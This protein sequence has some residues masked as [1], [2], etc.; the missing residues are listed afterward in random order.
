[1][2]GEFREVGF[3]EEANL[4]VQF[5]ETN[6]DRRRHFH[7]N[8]ILVK[9]DKIVRD[10]LI[11][12]L[13]IE[14]IEFPVEGQRRNFVV[15]YLRSGKEYHLNFQEAEKL[16]SQISDGAYYASNLLSKYQEEDT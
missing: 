6:I 3:V 1:M 8:L 4:Y 5:T 7:H 14:S 12:Y 15:I 2:T 11:N 9:T 10:V 13:H 16:L